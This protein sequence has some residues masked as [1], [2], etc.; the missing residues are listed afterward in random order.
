MGEMCQSSS[1]YYY[2]DSTTTV[3]SFN[4]VALVWV[5]F[6][7]RFYSVFREAINI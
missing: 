3:F 6:S 4:S 7:I 2:F 5:F 1:K